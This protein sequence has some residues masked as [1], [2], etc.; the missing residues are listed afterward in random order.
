[1]AIFVFESPGKVGPVDE[2]ESVSGVSVEGKG[3]EWKV[4]WIT[5]VVVSL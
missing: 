2:G 1:M 4:R 3:G 5:I